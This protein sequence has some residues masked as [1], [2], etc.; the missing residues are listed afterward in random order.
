MGTLSLAFR[1]D[2]QRRSGRSS[3]SINSD[4]SCKQYKRQREAS[5]V[6]RFPLYFKHQQSCQ[7]EFS[8]SGLPLSGNPT[9]WAMSIDGSVI[10]ES[11]QTDG[12]VFAYNVSCGIHY[13]EWLLHGH[14]LFHNI[15]DFVHSPQVASGEVDLSNQS[16]VKLV[17]KYVPATTTTHLPRIR[18]G[19][20]LPLECW[21]E[22][23]R[24]YTD[25]SR[26]FAVSCRDR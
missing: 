20:R 9:F 5:T 26:V 10:N 12:E 6:R 19:C 21:G 25:D 18:T 7:V 17:F 15:C 11:V 14:R 16:V 22:R 23:H 1:G 13:Y 24:P 2:E 4:R 3:I 8:E